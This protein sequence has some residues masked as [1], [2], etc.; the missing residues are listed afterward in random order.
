MRL[1]DILTRRNFVEQVWALALNTISPNHIFPWPTLS[2][3]RRL[4]LKLLWLDNNPNNKTNF[5]KLKNHTFSILRKKRVPAE[6]HPIIFNRRWENFLYH[7][8]HKQ[9]VFSR[10]TISNETSIKLLKIIPVPKKL[11]ENIPLGK[12]WI[13]VLWELNTLFLIKNENW[14]PKFIQ[15]YSVVISP[16]WYWN[17][18]DSLKTPLGLHKITT[19]RKTSYVSARLFEKILWRKAIGYTKPKNSKKERFLATTAFYMYWSDRN[20]NWNSF[21]RGIAMHGLDKHFSIDLSLNTPLK[22]WEWCIILWNIDVIAIENDVHLQWW[23]MNVYI[24]NFWQ[25]VS[26]WNLLKVALT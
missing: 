2:L 25:Y 15:S 7:L 9:E 23:E 14:E 8:N 6:L 13:F 17:K 11:I 18:T 4:A 16:N 26:E 10:K 21:D 20:V 12:K 24:S 19:K 22:W 5:D 1:T 3:T